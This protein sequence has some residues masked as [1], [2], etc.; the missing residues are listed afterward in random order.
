[1]K[2][3]IPTIAYYVATSAVKIFMIYMAIYA[4]CDARREVVR[5]FEAVEDFAAEV[6]EYALLGIPCIMLY[7]DLW[8][9][10]KKLPKW[11]SKKEDEAQ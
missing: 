8:N 7:N 9:L 10:R 6:W 3:K 4:L 2:N 11:D 5:I 1:M